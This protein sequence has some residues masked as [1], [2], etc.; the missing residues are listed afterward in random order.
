M[1]LRFLLPHKFKF[2]GIVIFIIGMIGAYLRFYLGIKPTVLNVSVFAVYSSFLD[3]KT[4]SVITNNIS[5]E[6]IG[7]L[8]SLGLIFI[9][10]SKETFEDEIVNSLRLRSFYY[11]VLTNTIIMIFSIL[12]IYGFAFLNVLIINLFSQLMLYQLFFKLSLILN[13]KKNSNE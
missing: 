7:L 13:Y 4:F 3:T 2:V 9:N 5:D 8:L 10:F 11:S 12:F 1:N 6:I